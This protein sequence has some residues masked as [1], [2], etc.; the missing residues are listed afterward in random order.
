VQF[1]EKV[2]GWERPQLEP[3]DPAIVQVA[4]W[5]LKVINKAAYAHVPNRQLFNELDKEAIL[6]GLRSK[7]VLAE[8][9][10]IE[11]LLANFRCNS[12]SLRTFLESVS[13]FTTTTKE[14]IIRKGARW[15]WMKHRHVRIQGV[16]LNNFDKTSW[17]ET[18]GIIIDGHHIN[19]HKNYEGEVIRV[20]NKTCT[21]A[22]TAGNTIGTR[23]E[24]QVPF[25]YLVDLRCVNL[26]NSTAIYLKIS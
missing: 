21:V 2:L 14:F 24:I 13:T 19:E 26:T 23:Q 8:P 15:T 25:E 9:Q 20:N 6:S 16:D 10:E 22:V 12:S 4:P 11:S 17:E 3:E 7:A 18:D 1:F 5:H